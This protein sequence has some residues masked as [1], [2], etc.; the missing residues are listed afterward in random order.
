MKRVGAA[1]RVLIGV[2]AP[3]KWDYSLPALAQYTATPIPPTNEWVSES[4][5]AAVNGTAV[6]PPGSPQPYRPRHPRSGKVMRHVLHARAEATRSLASFIAQLEAGPSDM[7]VHASVH[8][9]RLYGGVDTC[10]DLGH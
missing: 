1:W 9:A 10:G 5:R 4:A 2:W 6:K 8:L 7:R 3:K